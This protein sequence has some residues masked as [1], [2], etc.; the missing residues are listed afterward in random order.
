MVI[1]GQR[2]VVA[3]VRGSADRR[4]AHFAL[5]P[6][7]KGGFVVYKQTVDLVNML[8]KPLLLVDNDE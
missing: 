3:R 7:E 1:V 5:A 6:G 4:P 2:A 8:E